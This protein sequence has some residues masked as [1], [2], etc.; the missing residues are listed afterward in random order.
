M[1]LSLEGNLGGKIVQNSWLQIVISTSQDV[2]WYVAVDITSLQLVSS[3]HSLLSG[4]EVHI[5]TVF[6]RYC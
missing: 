2:F 3:L 5:I 4:I 6:R 1:M